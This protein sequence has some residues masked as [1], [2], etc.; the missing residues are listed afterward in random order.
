MPYCRDCGE[1]AGDILS[2]RLTCESAQRP[3]DAGAGPALQLAGDAAAAWRTDA[4]AGHLILHPGHS[5]LQRG[6]PGGTVG[7]MMAR[8]VLYCRECNA[9]LDLQGRAGRTCGAVWG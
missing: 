9:L 7:G 6:H 2:H 3:V 5:V 4:V 1:F 8:Q